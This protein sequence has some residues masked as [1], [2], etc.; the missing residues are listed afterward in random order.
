MRSWAL[1]QGQSSSRVLFTAGHC[2]LFGQWSAS[3][4]RLPLHPSVSSLQVFLQRLISLYLCVLFTATAVACISEESSLFCVCVCFFLPNPKGFWRT[5]ISSEEKTH[6][7]SN[8]RRPQCLASLGIRAAA[9]GRLNCKPPFVS[10]PFLCKTSVKSLS[11]HN[12]KQ[13]I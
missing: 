13:L 4:S 6:Q 5:F 8:S 3:I 12:S 7:S 10:P 1:L 2:V 11:S 9:L